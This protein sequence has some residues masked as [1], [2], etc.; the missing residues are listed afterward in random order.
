MAIEESEQAASKPFGKTAATEVVRT[1]DELHFAKRGESL[2]E[3]SSSQEPIDGYDPELMGA[4]TLLTAKEEKKLLRRIDWRLM[5]L[6]SLLFMFKNLDSTNVRIQTHP[7][8]NI[9]LTVSFTGLQCSNH[10]QGDRPEHHKTAWAH[11]QRV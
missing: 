1:G 6:C 7:N 2:T 5:T 4:R 9:H 11:I 10:E 3:D 8:Q